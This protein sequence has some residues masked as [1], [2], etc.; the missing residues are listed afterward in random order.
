MSIQL[1]ASNYLFNGDTPSAPSITVN[2]RTVTQ[3]QLD[4]ATSAYSS[5]AEEYVL[6]YQQIF[7][8]REYVVDRLKKDLAVQ[9]EGLTLD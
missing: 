8:D 2:I 9:C 7:E 5:D 6:E 1:T 3:E 4:S